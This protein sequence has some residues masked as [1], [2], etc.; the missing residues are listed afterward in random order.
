MK[1]SQRENVKKIANWIWQSKWETFSDK[2]FDYVWSMN[3][4]Y[5]HLDN[6]YLRSESLIKNFNVQKIDFEMHTDQFWDLNLKLLI[7]NRAYFQRESW[8]WS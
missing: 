3:E 2:W 4:W 8:L 7:Q 1:N 6:C 5:N